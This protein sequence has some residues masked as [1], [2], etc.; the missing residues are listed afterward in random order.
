MFIYRRSALTLVLLLG[1]AFVHA[2]IGITNK[3]SD[4]RGTKHNLSAAVDGSST[5]SGGTVPTRTV[6][7]TSETQVCVFCHTPHGANTD[8]PSPLWNR[9]L[10]TETYKPLTGKVYNSTSM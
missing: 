8:I 1:A 4:V 2:Q 5:P 9:A 7:A 10:S 3:I 6:K